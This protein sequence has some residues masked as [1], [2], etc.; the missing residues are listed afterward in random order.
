MEPGEALHHAASR[1]DHDLVVQLLTL[2]DED[3][4]PAVDHVL[5]SQTSLSKAVQRNHEGVARLLLSHKANAN[6]I[7]QCAWRPLHHAVHAGNARTVKLLLLHRAHPGVQGTA[8]RSTPLPHELAHG[9]SSA[10]VKAMLAEAAQ[11]M[12]PVSAEAPLLDTRTLEERLMQVER[13]HPVPPDLAPSREAEGRSAESYGEELDA[14]DR[15]VSVELTKPIHG[16][17]GMLGHMPTSRV[18]ATR[19]LAAAP[20]HL[21]WSLLADEGI[22]ADTEVWV[23]GRM[24]R[25]LSLSELRAHEEA[26]FRLT[27]SGDY[28]VHALATDLMTRIYEP[29]GTAAEE[30]REHFEKV[31]SGCD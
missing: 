14:L 9:A 3:H 22:G 25:Q 5:H 29:G 12:R 19:H 8:G 21:V 23:L 15:R 18:E 4:R 24:R 6:G 7:E 10:L 20:P 30:L 1:G 28:R 17:L 2:E 31:R 27:H 16:R 11:A 26:L 13:L